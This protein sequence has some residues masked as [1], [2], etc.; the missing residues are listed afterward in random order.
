MIRRCF[1]LCS[2]SDLMRTC[3]LAVV[4]AILL[5]A[6]FAA[7]PPA[8]AQS[9]F[10][11]LFGYT[12]K[13]AQP[14]ALR[15]SAPRSPSAYSGYGYGGYDF[16]GFGFGSPQYRR[17]GSSRYKTYCVRICDGFYFPL[18]S[19]TSRRTFYDDGQECAKRC[20]TEARL[21]YLSRHSQ[22]IDNMVDL[23]GRRYA[24]LKN[25]FHYRKELKAGCTCQPQP[26]SA[27]SRARHR[28]YAYLDDLD[29]IE[30][31]RARQIAE[32]NA[33]VAANTAEEVS[34]QNTEAYIGT[35]PGRYVDETPAK[36]L[37]YAARSRS[38]QKRRRYKKPKR[39]KAMSSIWS[40][41]GP[42]AFTWPGEAPRRRR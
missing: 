28:Y 37:G 31:Q 8:N 20:G 22:S 33:K 26:W 41:G 35:V 25:A 1:L 5:T 12:K 29:K 32:R 24:S 11:A 23:T 10:Q 30:T 27:R 40:L 36:P 4:A 21:F 17:P 16:R 19:N 42:K 34:G 14:K 7:S 15:Y 18:R 38:L 39:K 6:L 3:R 2:M 13:P 9:F